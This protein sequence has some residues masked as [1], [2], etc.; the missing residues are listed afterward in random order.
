MRQRRMGSGCQPLSTLPWWVTTSL[1]LGLHAA[2]VAVVLPRGHGEP[3]S[4]AHIGVSLVWLDAA[5]AELVEASS[6][7]RAPAVSEPAA[8]APAARAAR[9]ARPV[10]REPPITAPAVT[11]VQPDADAVLAFAP[12]PT[13]PVR[14]EASAPANAEL[15]AKTGAHPST[16]PAATS[17]DS[18][19]K[20][21]AG[22]T[23]G[24]RPSLP[25]A[26]K[27]APGLLAFTDPCRGYYPSGAAAEHGEV[28]LVVEVSAEGY[29]GTSH[30][31]VES[32]SLQGFANAA[33]ACAK[34]LRFRPA[35]D[36]EGVAIPGRAVLALSFDRP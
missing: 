24:S 20:L 31:T 16:G 35:R 25:A 13:P 23:G 33:R 29:T 3:R 36:E 28:Q 26:P 30:V 18:R 27:H 19:G 14:D 2:A 34:R 5:A 17:G 15:N 1:A 4:R 7:E 8:P 22:A 10:L 6:G 12:E 21:I 32:P 9:R 11:E